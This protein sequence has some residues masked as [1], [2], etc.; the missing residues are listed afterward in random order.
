KKGISMSAGLLTAVVLLLPGADPDPAAQIQPLEAITCP[1]AQIETSGVDG[2]ANPGG[3][4][5]LFWA[6]AEYLL[7]W[8]RKGPLPV[9]LVTQSSTFGDFP[10][11]ALGQ[12]GT[13]V[14]Y[15]GQGINFG[16]TSGFRISAGLTLMPDGGLSVEGS[17]LMLEKKAQ[18]FSAH[19]D[20]A[21]FPAIAQ[22]IFNPNSGGQAVELVPLPNPFGFAGGIQVASTSRLQG[23]DVNLGMGNWTGTWGGFVLLAGFRSLDLLESLTVNTSFQD[24]SGIPGG[25]G[26][27]FLG[28]RDRAG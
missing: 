11:G 5:G 15:G 28:V 27:T 3:G 4:P 17:W 24:V 12:P 19:S 7:W 1:E 25:A 23:W 10:I 13:Q 18:N 14:V 8:T 16:A 21:G 26:L 9:P 2:P 20:S 22:P 6:N